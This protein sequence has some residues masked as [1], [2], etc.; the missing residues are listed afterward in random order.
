MFSNFRAFLP[1]SPALVVSPLYSLSRRYLAAGS[2]HQSEPLPLSGA[3]VPSALVL[4]SALFQFHSTSVWRLELDSE[5][6][7]SI[8]SFSS[9]RTE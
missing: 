7:R 6:A 5:A 9:T 8:S 1:F 2:V 4:T 3:I